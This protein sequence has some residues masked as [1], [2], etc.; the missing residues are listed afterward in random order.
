MLSNKLR[1]PQSDYK[2]RNLFLIEQ[3]MAAVNKCHQI[4]LNS[5]FLILNFI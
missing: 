2:F 5:Q 4:I 1:I 3:K